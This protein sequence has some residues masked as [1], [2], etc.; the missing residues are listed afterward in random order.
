MRGKSRALKKQ[1]QADPKYGSTTVAKFINYIMKSGKKSTAQTIVYKAFDYVS[2]NTKQ[3][4]LEIFDQAIRNVTPAMEVKSR[5][6]GGANYQIPLPVRGDRKNALIF[7][8]I[9]NAARVRKGKPMFLKLGD[10]IIAAAENRGDAIK[11]KD[12]VQRMAEA[13]RAFAHFAR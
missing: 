10:E 12:D 4:A 3:D 1:I 11:K 5:R 2:K 6:I 8:W 9:I 13:N 7:R